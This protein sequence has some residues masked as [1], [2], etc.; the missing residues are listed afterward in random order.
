MALALSVATPTSV[1]AQNQ[2]DLK[3]TWE[4]SLSEDLRSR[5]REDRQGVPENPFMVCVV[6]IPG[7]GKTT[8]AGILSELLDDVGC[9]FM[10]FDGYHV[11]LEQLRKRPDAKDAIY[12]RGAPDTFDSSKLKDDLLKIRCG[13][14][15]RVLVPGFDH[16]RGDPEPRKYSFQRSRHNIVVCE[17][18]YLLHDKDGWEDIAELF[19][20]SI[21]VDADLEICMERL[22]SRNKCI[23]GYTPEEIERRVDK[24]DR[25][26][27]L[28][29]M[30][31]KAR[32]NYV[33]Q[34]SAM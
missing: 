13:R 21:Y 1:P 24:V 30:Q 9:M 14:G 12:R 23:P 33:V 10:P 26:N 6:G 34:S 3:L 31:S 11:P 2:K 32:A 16:A 28:T 29:V 7:S 5:F 19:D 27:A 4:P 22:K 20:L 8:S 25:T 17:G 15:N 18:L